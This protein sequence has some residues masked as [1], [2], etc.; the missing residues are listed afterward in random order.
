MGFVTQE[1]SSDSD[2]EPSDQWLPAYTLVLLGM[3]FWICILQV[4]MLFAIVLRDS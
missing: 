4:L 1:E 3:V 2:H